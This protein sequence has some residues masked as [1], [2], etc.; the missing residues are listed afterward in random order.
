M[1]RGPGRVTRSLKAIFDRSPDGIFTTELLCRRVYRMAPVEKK[2]RVAVLRALKVLA[3]TTMPSLW[4]RA[5]MHQRDDEWYDRRAFPGR[6]R[7][8]APAMDPRPRKG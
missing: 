6:P 1:S 3:N 7:G 4:R 2:H 8:A 5:A